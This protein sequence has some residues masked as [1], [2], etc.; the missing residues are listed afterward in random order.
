MQRAISGDCVAWKPEIAPQA[1]EMNIIGKMG[2]LGAS[3]W[4]FCRPL[5]SSGISG[6]Y[7]MNATTIATAIPSSRMPKTG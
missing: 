5:H 1:M 7:K 2:L 4:R 3:G 6:L